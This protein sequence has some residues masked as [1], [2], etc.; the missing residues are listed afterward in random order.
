MTAFAERYG[1]WA[2]VT[3][4]G[5]GIGAAFAADLAARGVAPIVVDRDAALVDAR[6]AELIDA[7]TGARGVVV[8][9]ATPGGAGELLDALAGLDVGLLVSNAA[10]SYEGPFLAQ[11]LAAGLIQLDVN[12]RAPLTLVH[13]MLPRLV[14]RG[15]GGMILL[16]SLS[17]MRGAPLVAGYAATKAW[18]LVLAE[19]LW[20]E[21]REYGV[22]VMAVVPGSTRTPGW[23]ASRPQ[24]SLG[25]ANV[26]EP[27]DVAAEA[28]DALGRGPS[29]VPGSANREAEAFM[30]SL[31]RTEAIRIMGDV[32]RQMYPGAQEAAPPA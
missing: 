6:V 17:A 4:A 25:T 22:D 32:M 27:A 18:N 19:S 5:Q 30:A 12:C 8:D 13:G 14:E 16:S 2:A 21:L 26:M 29:F 20:D 9:L 15:R 23:L 10:L 31:D 11:G 7:G 24:P 3:G 28:L 1:P